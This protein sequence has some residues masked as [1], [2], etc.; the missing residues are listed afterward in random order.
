MTIIK[1]V[2]MNS[3]EHAQLLSVLRM[4]G[5]Y[6]DAEP[7][8]CSVRRLMDERNTERATAA[9][10]LEQVREL[11]V[12]TTSQAERI[13]QLET[14][15]KRLS[16]A[17]GSPVGWK[18][19]EARPA[20]PP[21]PPPYMV[22]DEPEIDRSRLGRQRRELR[23]LNAAQRANRNELTLVTRSLE[24]AATEILRLRHALRIAEA[25]K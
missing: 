18:P 10:R 1:L 24:D 2:K 17:P 7:E 23:R 21:A 16:L 13:R 8:Y 3:L 14:E 19:P 15:I 25:V 9:R 6:N 20:V 11:S 5:S 12:L 22:T 4:S